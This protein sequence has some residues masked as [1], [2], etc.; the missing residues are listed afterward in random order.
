MKLS[1]PDVLTAH[2]DAAP[3]Q[4]SSLGSGATLSWLDYLR[5]GHNTSKSGC[6]KEEREQTHQPQRHEH[7][8]EEAID[9]GPVASWNRRLMKTQ[10]LQPIGVSS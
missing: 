5:L 3:I 4:P 10:S 6:Q 8:G 2:R 7:V 9:V 1:L